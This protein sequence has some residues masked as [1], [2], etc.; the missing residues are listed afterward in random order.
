MSN[1]FKKFAEQVNKK[2]TELSKQKLFVVD[3]SKDELWSAYL[4]AFPEGTNPIFRERPEHDCQC[5]K[6]FIVR[7]GK[8]VAIAAGNQIQTVW[9]IPNAP[10]FY[11]DVAKALDT[12]IKSKPIY[13]PFYTNEPKAGLRITQEVTDSGTIDW[14]HFFF[15]IPQNYIKSDHRTVVGKQMS[16]KQVLGRGL[17]EITHDALDII[18]DLIYDNAIYR[19]EEF[20]Q[21]VLDFKALKTIYDGVH[22]ATAK[23]LF[24]W[25]NLDSS[26]ARIRNTAIGT[27]LQDLSENIDL[28]TA[29]TKFEKVVAPDNYKRTKSVVTKGM[30]DNALKAI[31]DAGIEQS[32]HRRHAQI[33]DVSVNDVIYVDRDSRSK[34]KDSL[35]EL[36]YSGTPSKSKDFS[37]VQEISIEDF[38]TNIVPT[39]ETIEAQFE[40]K[41]AP[42][43][44]SLIAPTYADAPNIL[45]WDNNFSHSY[46]GGLTDSGMKEKVKA[47]GGN[48][49]GALRFSIQW[50]TAEQPCSS[51]YDAHCQSPYEHISYASKQGGKYSGTLDVDI[52]RPNGTAVENIIYTDYTRM[53]KGEYKMFVHN[54]SDRSGFGFTAEIECNG[55]I[56][57]FECMKHFTGN[58]H[59]AI[60]EHDGNGNFKVT[61]ANDISC[62]QTPIT[63]WG[64]TAN[65]FHKVQSICLSPNHWG[66]N[67]VGNKHYFFTLENCLNPEPIRGLYNEFLHNK[68]SDHRKAFDMLGS[69]L[70]VPYSEHQMSGLGFSSTLQSELIVKVTG[71][72]NKMFKIKFA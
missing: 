26:A 28:D 4:A 49:E 43:L 62:N 45:K 60:V 54:Y 40:N 27:L 69:K 34:M 38:I 30:R 35:E 65:K 33:E 18:L 42:K 7:V 13:E 66:D 53:P 48:V 19:G 21:Q 11:K 6:Q 59:V 29:V 68:F 23:P 55:Q 8:C 15:D 22:P 9:D 56:Y 3:I 10:G 52:I 39:A 51:D 14:N 41:L 72:S 71:A 37:K 12:L 47:A 17:E 44:F 5:C 32:L 57:E 36:M 16:T 25:N 64:I 63:E 2:V 31:K 61:P 46:K 67:A 1:D 50:N 20:K 24:V 58:K 70:E